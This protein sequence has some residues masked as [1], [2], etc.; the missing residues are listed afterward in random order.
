MGKYSPSEGGSPIFTQPKTL[1]IISLERLIESGNFDV[2]FY[3]G[4]YSDLFDLS[5]QALIEHYCVFGRKEGRI[6]TPI[7]LRQNL[8][9]VLSSCSSIIEIGPFCNPLISSE[10][11]VYFDVLNTE[12]LLKRAQK[13]GH[14]I[15]S[16]PQIH[17][18]SPTGD[19]SVVDRKFA[20]AV[21]SHCV[22]HQPDLIRHLQQVHYLLEPSG[23]YCLLIPDKRYCFDH[24]LAESNL[25]QILE[26]H[27]EGR[28]KHTLSRVIEHRA[29]TTHNNP[30]RHWNGDHFD[31][32]WHESISARAKSAIVEFEAAAGTYIDVHAWQFTPE[33]FADII[34][35]LNKMG[36][37]GLDVAL[38]CNT[39]FGNN[40][41]VCILKKP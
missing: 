6:S 12:E 23:Y 29:L 38:V 27:N 9:N 16:V 14:P 37:I 4:H 33:S 8:V 31:P 19:L 24:A 34:R 32:Q 30:V 18:V 25:A 35:T 17:Y 28:R 7:A 15:R 10:N 22:E 21:S 41:F 39:P 5:D 26:A 11:V 13:I 2:N 1:P 40:E 20:L 3:R 36:L